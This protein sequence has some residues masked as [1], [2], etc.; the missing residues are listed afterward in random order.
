MKFTK[1]GKRIF[2]SDDLLP[3]NTDI[4]FLLSSIILDRFVLMF[5]LF[6]SKG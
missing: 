4:I 1:M 3:A 2:V 5:S 6:S